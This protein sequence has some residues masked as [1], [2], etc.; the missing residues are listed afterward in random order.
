M[1]VAFTRFID[2]FLL[3]LLETAFGQIVQQF[4]EWITQ[5]I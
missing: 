3:K 4:V 2:E 5:Y 1:E